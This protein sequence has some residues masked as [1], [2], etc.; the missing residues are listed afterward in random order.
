MT[1]NEDVV[2][3]Q[4]RSY[5]TEERSKLITAAFAAEYVSRTEPR[6]R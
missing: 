2:I 1:G 6:T 4:D 5:R 3:D